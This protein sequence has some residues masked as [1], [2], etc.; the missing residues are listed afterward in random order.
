[1]HTILINEKK[2][3]CILVGRLYI[4]FWTIIPT[5]LANKS[6]EFLDILYIDFFFTYWYLASFCFTDT[7]FFSI[8]SVFL[9]TLCSASLDASFSAGSDADY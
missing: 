2:Q 8:I 3:F 9:V 1:M 4:Y 5:F 7:A 6:F